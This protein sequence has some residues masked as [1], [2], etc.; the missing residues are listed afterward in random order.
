M[1][2][3]REPDPPVSAGKKG[4]LIV[5]EFPYDSFWSYRYVIRLIGRKAAF[6][7]LGLLTFAAHLPEE[8]DLEVVDLNVVA[9]PDRVLRSKIAEADAAFV[10]AM[11]IQKRS[12][13]ELLRGPASGCDTPFVLGGPFASSYRDEIL[14][15]RSDSDRI[16]HAGLDV[17]VWG[18][19]RA[20]MGPLLEYLDSGPS[21][22]PEAPR[23]L[24]P[25]PI[26][27][28]DPGSRRHLN[29]RSI[30]EPLDDVPLPRWDL[31]R[32]G[33]YQSMMIQT[34]A[35]CPFRCDF[36]DIIQF[37]GGF[38]RPK[39]PEAV[40]RELQAILDTGYRGGVFS[41]DDNFVGSPAAISEILDG[42]IE[43]QRE[44]DY[45]F[46][47]YTQASVNLGTPKLE[48]LIDKMKL[49]GFG[50]VFLGVENPDEGALRGMNK[51]QNIKVDVPDAIAGIQA[52]G[53]EVYAG[54]ILGSDE[55]T[56]STADRIVEFVRKARIFSA[57]TG[58]LTPVPHTPL[59][60]RLKREGRLRPA[61]YSGNNTDDEVQ[62]E[63][64]AMSAER[65]RQGI[66]DI[67]CRL[68][69][70][71][72]SYH[73]ALEMLRA[74]RPHIFSSRHLDPRYIKGALVSVWKQGLRRLDRDYFALLWNAARLDRELRRRTEGEARRLRRLLRGL[75]KQ[76]AVRLAQGRESLDELVA[77][78]RD[79]LV[80]F[81]PER[82]LEEVR[83]WVDQVGGH[84]RRQGLL[85]TEEA[86]E[87]LE[88]AV[89]YLKVRARCHRFPGVKLRGAL[90]AAIKGLH[91]EQVVSSIVGA[92]PEPPATPAGRARCSLAQARG[93]ERLHRDGTDGPSVPSC[94][95]LTGRGRPFHVSGW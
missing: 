12:L 79:Y 54:F 74:V 52:S 86:R 42:M 87:V 70:P 92:G 25:E 84:L 23:L 33:D 37:N 46:T 67:L 73:R 71:P 77:L 49:A 55:D 44:H 62:F 63:P 89:R 81:R 9:L 95:S 14:E 16:L 28:V 27:K 4:L 19:A 26:E 32:V 36:C 64:R 5:P 31:I 93:M 45:P 30:F 13:V 3:S 94:R 22:D 24:I 78:A 72:E 29:D 76:R 80:R 57:M 2:V 34:T 51:K 68:F 88:N 60:E 66:H 85:H 17:L 50:A 21:H 41:V 15:P 8:W 1:G 56:P 40:R 53:M 47:F 35:G 48:H 7:P 58:M 61:E 39:S 65:L 91:Y 10:S 75:R 18:E 20:A 43:F 69:R 38:N 11:S 6:P 83:D 90:E 82:S 59:Y